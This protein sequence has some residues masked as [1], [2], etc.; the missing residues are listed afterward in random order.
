MKLEVPCSI[1][2]VLCPVI[3]ADSYNQKAQNQNAG[4]YQ[5]QRGYNYYGYGTDSSNM[6]A[7]D[8]WYYQNYDVNYI[9]Q[10]NNNDGNFQYYDADGWYDASYSSAGYYDENGSF[11]LYNYQNYYD[12]DQIDDESAAA[13]YQSW[14]T[15]GGANGY[16]DNSGNWMGTQY[17]NVPCMS[18]MEQSGNEEGDED[19]NE[20]NA[21]YNAAWASQNYDGQDAGNN[22]W[23][24][25][26]EACRDSTHI[27]TNN[28]KNSVV[29]VKNVTIYCDSPYRG[30]FSKGAHMASEL[31]EYGDHA[32]VMVFFD[33]TQDLDWRQSIYMTFGI[34]AGKQTKELLWAVRSVELCN[35]FVGH[36]CARAGSY[37]FA[38]QVTFDYGQMSDRNLFVPLIEM[39]FSTRPDEGYNLGGLNINCKF[40]SFYQ[41]YDPWYNGKQAHASQSW[42]AGGLGKAAGQYGILVGVLLLS[43]AFALFT[44]TRRKEAIEFQGNGDD[45]LEKD[46]ILT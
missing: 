23:Q 30:Y 44:W 3:K 31:C 35:T 21:Y 42:G 45:F 37:A 14:Q 7:Y 11:H 12:G 13:Y 39:G 16:Y 9:Q 17:E 41:Q 1:I 4:N 33:V 2:F 27:R 43:I 46:G 19:G 29:Q 20:N 34:Y 38:F 36:N 5:A 25:Y 22:E 15:S 18:Y 6:T 26:L 32:V 40:N 8:Q 24:Q 10:M 28:C